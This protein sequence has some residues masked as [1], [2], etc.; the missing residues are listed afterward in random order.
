MNRPILDCKLINFSIYGGHDN[1]SAPC[2]LSF[3]NKIRKTLNMCDSVPIL[4]KN[5]S[6]LE[7]QCRGA[8]HK[9]NFGLILVSSTILPARKRTLF[10]YYSFSQRIRASPSSGRGQFRSE[11]LAQPNSHPTPQALTFIIGGPS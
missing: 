1:F 5:L 2:H 11:E 6:P 7:E 9:A 4:V 8:P 10:Q 3:M